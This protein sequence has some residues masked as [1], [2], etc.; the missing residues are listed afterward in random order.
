MAQKTKKYVS[1]P[2]EETVPPKE[3]NKKEKIIKYGILGLFLIILIVL[4]FYFFHKNDY[5]VSF[6]IDGKEYLL[7]NVHDAKELVKPKEPKKEGYTF[8]G[9]YS[10]GKKVDLD[11][12]DLKGN[13]ELEAH[14]VINSYTVTIDDG[15][16]NV[17]ELEVTHDEK[18]E[19]PEMND[20]KGYTFGGWFQGEEP[21]DFA[22][23]VTEDTK[24]E[25]RWIEKG[26]ATYVIEHYLMG[27]DGEY[28][29]VEDRSYHSGKIDSDVTPPTNTYRGFTSPDRKRV[30]VK[31][32]GTTTV[33]YYY[34]RNKYKLTLKEDKGISSVEGSGTYYYGEKVKL[35][36]TIKAGYQFL[37]WSKKTEEGTYTM[38][39]ENTTLTAETTPIEYTITYELNGG[40]GENQTTYT[41]EDPILLTSPTKD[42]YT[43]DGWYIDGEKVETF[44]GLLGDLTIE[45]KFVVNDDTAYTVEHYE[46]DTDGNYPTT[47]TKTESK[48]G[49]T[50]TS[51]LKEEDREV[52]EV[53]FTFD[54]KNSS[55]DVL[56]TGDGKAVVK[57]YY[58]RNQYTL[59][60]EK[61]TGIE[62]V[63]GA[64]TYYYGK[65]VSVSATPKAGYSFAHWSNEEVNAAFTYIINNNITLTATATPNEDT[66]YT[67]EHYLMKVDGTYSDKADSTKEKTGTTD[68]S[69]LKEED[70]EV[71]E[72]GFTFDE[73]NSSKDVLITG[74]GKAVVKYYYKRKT[75]T[76]TITGQEGIKTPETPSKESYHYGEEITLDSKN[77]TYEEGYEFSHWLVDGETEEGTTLTFT[78]KDADMTVEVVAKKT[79]YTLT[80]ISETTEKDIK[81]VKFTIGTIVDKFVPA[82][83]T[84][85]HFIGWYTSPT[86]E[87]DTKVDLTQPMKAG[88][89][90]VYAKWEINHNTFFFESLKD[91]VPVDIESIVQDYGTS[92][93]KPEDPTYPG[94]TFDGWYDSTGKNPLTIP[95]TMPQEGMTFY[96]K[97][98][99]NR[100][101]VTFDSNTGTGEMK[102][103]EFIYD[104]E[105]SLTSNSFTKTG[106]H[107]VGWS[108]TKEN[109]VKAY[110][111][112]KSVKNIAGKDKD[113][114]TLTLYAMWEANPYKVK[115]HGNGATTGEDFEEEFTYDVEKE[116]NK[117]QDKFTKKGYTF[118]GWTKDT[119]NNKLIEEKMNYTTEGT[120]DVYAVWKA[121]EYTVNYDSNKG[122]GYSEPTG[123]VSSTTHT[124]DEKENLSQTHYEREGY[125]FVGWSTTKHESAIDSSE[126]CSDCITTADNLAEEGTVTVYAVWK[127]NH[128]TVTLKD[129][130]NDKEESKDYTIETGTALED[131][132][133]VEGYTF[134][135]WYTTA[136]FDEGTKKET[137]ETGS[138]DNI[139]LYAKWRENSYKVKYK[140][141]TVE[142]EDPTTYKYTESVT[143]KGDTEFTKS[144]TV[145]F[146]DGEKST[147]ET[148]D[149]TYRKWKIE[150]TDTTFDINS[151]QTKL[152]AADGATVTLVPVW[153]NPKL[154]E[155]ITPDEKTG[156]HFVEWQLNGVGVTNDFVVEH[157]IELTAKWEANTYTAEFKHNNGTEA[158]TSKTFT[159][160]SQN[161]AASADNITYTHTVTWTNEDSQ[162][163][164]ETL[165]ATLTG[166]KLESGEDDTCYKPGEVM[167]KDFA[168]E[169]DATVT[170]VAC[171]EE[172]TLTLPTDEFTKTGY[173]LDGWYNDNTKVN[174]GDKVPSDLNINIA[175][176]WTAIQYKVIFT[177]GN[178]NE[179]DTPRTFTYDKGNRVPSAS[180][181]GFSR[182]YTLTLNA[183]GGNSDKEI[184]KEA[185]L[186]KWKV[187]DGPM[188]DQIF[189]PS[190][191]STTNLSTTENETIHIEA[192]WKGPQ[193]DISGETVTK[194]GYKFLGWLKD[195]NP[196]GN[197]ITLNSDLELT[198]SW[199]AITY[200]TQYLDNSGKLKSK[201]CTFD[202][203]CLLEN[204]NF[205]DQPYTITFHLSNGETKK[206]TTGTPS[207]DA[208]CRTS[209]GNE[210]REGAIIDATEGKVTVQN[211]TANDGETVIVNRSV[212]VNFPEVL[213][214]KEDYVFGGWTIKEKTENPEDILGYKPLGEKETFTGEYSYASDKW[215]FIQDTDVYEKWWDVPYIES[216]GFLLEPLPGKDLKSMTS[217][218]KTGKRENIKRSSLYIKIPE[219][220]DYYVNVFSLF[221]DI[222][223]PVKLNTHTARN[224]GDIY[225][226]GTQFEG[227]PLG[228]AFGE[229]ENKLQTAFP[230]TSTDGKKWQIPYDEMMELLNK[231]DD[232]AG[233][234][235]TMILQLFFTGNLFSKNL[236]TE[237][238]LNG[239]NLGVAANFGCNG[240]ACSPRYESI[241]VDHLN[242]SSYYFFATEEDFKEQYTVQ[243]KFGDEILYSFKVPLGSP[244]PN[245]G[246]EV[247]TYT[248]VRD[249][250]AGLSM[251]PDTLTPKDTYN[252]TKWTLEDNTTEYDFD[253][254]V[255]E[256]SNPACTEKVITIVGQG[257][258]VTE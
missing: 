199:K 123:E 85:H 189:T 14:F 18:I 178:G 50:D 247:T 124:Y 86:F 150:D 52:P 142:K 143:L 73:E 231:E 188:K 10:D 131:P 181:L 95:D 253:K 129:K 105:Q 76:L 110:D 191:L 206:V 203:P 41:V 155:T 200:T 229:V 11:S 249:S 180:N 238:F 223:Q 244:I 9:W 106:Y 58:Q 198:A 115:Y 112:K 16:G 91:N 37:G 225:V 234:M 54:E 35:Q 236:Q 146:K 186:E 220:G 42:G 219:T 72:V 185:T 113:N 114:D 68:T 59:T 192:Q 93:T 74:D 13:L 218:V 117:N 141:G 208:V 154:S 157:D 135:G 5:A 144:Y 96:A 116:L 44:D 75:H 177:D 193:I 61:G 148:R 227:F 167:S 162:V 197:A 201:G 153:E 250:G 92:I 70:R 190:A 46:M 28:H 163:K 7:E 195:Q 62:S 133:K 90:T 4:L 251:N 2:K 233:S 159:Y 47:P 161:E 134:E 80:Y 87:E 8:D 63:S 78:M 216:V 26:Q 173:K 88:N 22:K 214:P 140:D 255:A 119:T 128:Y 170:F 224:K 23:G 256:D 243:Y 240:L 48:T 194:E 15:L 66:K 158:A 172:P 168:T 204:A 31:E 138:T 89:L 132:E 81:D 100:Y 151:N 109:P 39:A 49:T 104:E 212:E 136:T 57:Y 45:A 230:F 221:V 222:S 34:S 36:A 67:V 241:L 30:T 239:Q 118:Q 164:Q 29:Q 232:Q 245:L 122:N 139:D 12:L 210:C 1:T 213:E 21:F 257:T 60:L 137:I 27:L 33:K 32:D 94:Y 101:T 17:T 183:N 108:L 258:K 209:S 103:Q 254:N 160:G 99:A 111:D 171:W 98:H 38:P 121:N 184:T 83:W 242:G 179:Y 130:L 248:V 127:I 97:W 82:E 69:A 64:G 53:G 156:Y 174:S 246:S 125:T 211:L 71:P 40:V 166:W 77:T 152:I 145:T 65:E 147:P 228:I 51:A 205:S 187:L 19:E 55:K 120:I 56:I 176:K 175:T 196:V 202:Q 25:A 226:A 169:Q 79:I 24:I 237:L 3:D 6:M 207:A 126:E 235:F 20:R 182:T 43:F 165:S 215:S 252:I 217:E 149:L 102:P 84:G 107:F